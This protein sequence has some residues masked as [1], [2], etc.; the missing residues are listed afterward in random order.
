MNFIL[1]NG[2]TIF[3]A[4]GRKECLEYAKSTFGIN[5]PWRVR[6]LPGIPR[7]KE[8]L[9]L[10][11]H[12]ATTALVKQFR[13]EGGDIFWHVLERR[14]AYLSTCCTVTE[15]EMSRPRRPLL[16]GYMAIPDDELGKVMSE[17]IMPAQSGWRVL[18]LDLNP[19]CTPF[20][21]WE[22]SIWCYGDLSTA[23]QYELA[24]HPVFETDAFLGS[25]FTIALAAVVWEADCDFSRRTKAIHPSFIVPLHSG[26][27]RRGRDYDEGNYRWFR[28]CEEEAMKALARRDIKPHETLD[29]AEYDIDLLQAW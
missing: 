25:T 1:T 27:L 8:K 15:K 28:K 14:P 3:H 9:E 7:L 10:C 18:H 22:H 16:Y 29:T 4:G 13:R 11:T 26:F 19:G 24:E 23:L 6:H 5:D 21:Y 2:V 12:S 17:G 20:A